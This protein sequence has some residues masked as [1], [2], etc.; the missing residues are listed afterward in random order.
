MLFMFKHE[1]MKYIYI[2][3]LGNMYCTVCEIFP[4]EN[5]LHCG[6][7]LQYGETQVITEPEFLN[8]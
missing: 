8:L 2:P 1:L 7:K 3:C 5:M 6:Q 4:G